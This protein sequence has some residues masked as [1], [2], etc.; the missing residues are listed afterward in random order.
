MN[1]TNSNSITSILICALNA[2]SKFRT[3]MLTKFEEITQSK[4]DDIYFYDG[5]H[6]PLKIEKMENKQVDIY[7]R[8]FGEQKVRLMIEIKANLNEALQDSQKKNSIYEV[9]AKQLGCNL[10]YIVPKNYNHKNEL[11]T[12]IIEWETVL[13]IADKKLKQ[14]I[15]HFVEAD[16]DD[17]RQSVLSKQV[18]QLLQNPKQLQKLYEKHK[19][20]LKKCITDAGVRVKGNNFSITDYE[21]GYYFGSKEFF[22]GYTYIHKTFDDSKG[23]YNFFLCIQETKNNTILGKEDFYYDGGWYYIPIKRLENMNI[24]TIEDLRKTK[25]IKPKVY[26]NLNLDEIQKFEINNDVRKVYPII[27]MIKLLCEGLTSKDFENRDFVIVKDYF[28]YFFP[29]KEEPHKENDIFIG[30]DIIDKN[31]NALYFVFELYKKEWKKQ[32][33][34]ELEKCYKDFISAETLDMQKGKFAK[35]IQA[36]KEKLEK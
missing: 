27:R 6:S 11:S 16:I 21:F 13:E 4:L 24:K 3:E 22:L 29:E 33:L 35:L 28:G 17:D 34:E 9:V 20:N 36:A 26:Y 23:I 19:E 18:L 7:A 12:N 32:K 31:D 1:Q 10:L 2:K 5:T 14:Q 25:E 30:I 15:Y 8:K